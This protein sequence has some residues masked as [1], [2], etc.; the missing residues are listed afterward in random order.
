MRIGIFGGLSANGPIDR[1]VEDARTALDGGF[2][3]YWMPQIFGL[4]ALTTLA[5]VGRE[6]PDIEL[7]TAVIPTYPRHPMMLAAQALTTQAIT[8]GR[9]ALGIGLSH[10]LVI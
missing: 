8:G 10:Q 3:S 5:V 2:T 1:V 7:G 4:D 9:L 6:V